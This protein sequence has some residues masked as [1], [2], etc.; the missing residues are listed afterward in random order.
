VNDGFHVGGDQINMIGGINPTG[1]IV[2]ANPEPRRPGAST[3]NVVWS[4]PLIFINY[5]RTDTKAAAD[6]EA[7]LAR[8]LGAGVAFRDAQMPAGTRFPRELSERAKSC[9][10]MLS[11]IGDKWDAPHNLRL[12]N[13]E[14][15]WVRREIAIALRHRIPVVPILVGARGLLVADNLPAD[16]RA[17]AELQSPQLRRGYD[18]QDVQKLVD[19]LL[20]EVPTLAYALIRNRS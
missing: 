8:A 14:S 16:I 15:D 4:E 2:N 11:V 19:N 3:S 7:E 13:Q 12:L 17:I 9:K 10:V 18:A 20:R 5:R 1:K 6:I